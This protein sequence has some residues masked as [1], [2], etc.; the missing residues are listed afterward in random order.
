MEAYLL[1]LRNTE[2]STLLMLLP[3]YY[4]LLLPTL[5]LLDSLRP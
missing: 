3:A 4:L 1:T 5:L 2:V